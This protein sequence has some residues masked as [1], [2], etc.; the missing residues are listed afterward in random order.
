MS[1]SWRLL[2]LLL[3]AAIAAHVLMLAGHDPAAEAS[4]ADAAI[5]VGV[6]AQEP[7]MAQSGFPSG[8]PHH[9]A[10]VLGAACVV[11]LT[12]VLLATAFLRRLRLL[13]QLPGLR[14]ALPKLP[15]VPRRLP[16]RPP[17]T[18]VAEGVVLLT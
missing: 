10:A 2:T 11:V 14:V 4:A 7:L 13:Q 3:A 18:P 5:Y 6:H 1:T 8:Q 9:S 12:G 15:L 16:S 17:R